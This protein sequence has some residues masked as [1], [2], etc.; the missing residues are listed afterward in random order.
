MAR[1][2]L[3]PAARGAVRAVDDAGRRVDRHAIETIGDDAAVGSRRPAG[4][5]TDRCWDR[6]RSSAARRRPERHRRCRRGRGTARGIAGSTASPEQA[7]IPV[8][9]DVGPDVDRLGR[10]R[11]ALNAAIARPGHDDAALL[12]DEDPAVGR[13]RD[14]GRRDQ[15]ASR[16]SRRRSPDGMRLRRGRA[17]A[18]V[19]AP[20]G[21]RGERDPGAIVTAGGRARAG[22]APHPRRAVQVHGRPSRGAGVPGVQLPG[23]R[24]HDLSATP[25][26][27]LAQD[28]VHRLDEPIRVVRGEDQRRLDLHDVVERAVG[29]EEHAALRRHGPRAAVASSGAGSRVSR[30]RTS[31]I[32]MKR[33]MPRTSPIASCRSAT[34]RRPGEE[35]LPGDP[36]VLLE[37]LVDG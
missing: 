8:A 10:A 30:S 29:A 36:G 17:A 35:P 11:S 26:A 1:E 28:H 5:G 4:W 6:P 24:G 7:P 2:L 34:A 33:P 12:R 37:P 23:G 27:K 15:A 3:A 20:D 25:A 16:R 18:T 31:S 19:D 22:P 13:E 32:P 9:H 14:R 21:R